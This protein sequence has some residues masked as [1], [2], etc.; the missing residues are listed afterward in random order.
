MK[1]QYVFIFLICIALYI[2]YLIFSHKYKEYQINSKID[3]ISEL[4]QEIQWKIEE[5][6]SIIDY[7]TTAA[8]KNKI[9]KLEQWLKNKWE[10]VVYM[11]TEQKYKK[12][13]DTNI[14]EASKKAELEY[15]N[16]ESQ[17]DARSMTNIQKWYYFIF[18]KNK[19]LN[20]E[21]ATETS[22]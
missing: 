2:L 20:G 5:A 3:F 19:D 6:Q 7:K 16:L 21:K 9:L 10:K 14:E 1:K 17:W 18:Q 15:K 13:T 12:F 22:L 8:Y 4:N 11:T